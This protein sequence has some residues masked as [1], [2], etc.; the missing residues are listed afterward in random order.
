MPST[1]GSLERTHIV[2]SEYLKQ[3][4]NH[5][6]DW[7]KMVSFAMF[8]YNTSVNESTNFTAYEMIFGR[9][10][11]APSSLP[12]DQSLE[13]Y[14]DYL[15]ELV[16]RLNEIQY[17]EVKNLNL[18]KLREKYYYDTHVNPVTFNPSDQILV[19]QEPRKSKFK[20]QYHYWQ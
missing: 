19:I 5:V 15:V 12:E 11:R 13:T 14:S 3:A 6:E 4:V 17:M 9:N 1:N 2:L 20:S 7:D 18:A 16:Q 10:A 8:F